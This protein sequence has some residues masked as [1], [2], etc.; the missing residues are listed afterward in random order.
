MRN[1][2]KRTLSLVLAV[3]MLASVAATSI[4]VSANDGA[5]YMHTL[6]DAMAYWESDQEGCYGEAIP[7]TQVYF[8]MPEEWKNE[9]NDYYDGVSLDSCAAGVYWWSGSALPAD[10]LP[11][12]STNAWP[13]Y[14]LTTQEAPGVFSAAVPFDATEIIFNNTIDGGMDSTLDIYTLAVQTSNI[15]MAYDGADP[16]G[17]YP[18]G[19][20][21]VEGMIFVSDPEGKEVNPFNQKV[22]YAGAWFYYYGNGEYGTAPTKAEAGEFVYK[23]GEF[24]SSNLV[25]K[26]ETIN[27]GVGGT[28]SITAN[29]N[30]LTVTFSNEGIATVVANE[31]G[32]YTLQGVAAGTTT[33]TFTYTDEETQE[34]EE[35]TIEVT[36]VEPSFMP[37]SLTMNIGDLEFVIGLGLGENAV[38]SSSNN[39]VITVDSTGT[40]TAVGAGKADI[41]V[42]QGDKVVKCPVTVKAPVQPSLNKKTA[43]LAAGATTTITVKNG[44]ATSWKSSN[45]KVATVKNGKVT[46]LKKGTATITAK[47]NGKSLTC[48][49]TV[50]TNPKL[51]KSTITVKKNKSTTVNIIGAA[52]KPTVSKCQIAKITPSVKKLTI[53]AGKKAGSQKVT[54]T[55][56]GVKLKLTVKVK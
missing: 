4:S 26:P 35:D 3:L 21:S 50:S 37:D 23:N 11:W 20:T 55:V 53:K 17:F 29:K 30:P 52:S 19:L 32:T 56:N 9:H 34:T 36:I 49:V 16:Y 45:A 7:R 14:A 15:P 31:D 22:T 10:Y 24:P 46:A 33:A 40:V 51:A 8:Y 28:K 47:V 18:N 38:W 12:Y 39:K 5:K 54:V 42:T 1:T 41:V 27:V 48:K 6:E 25:V 44:K 2:L 43:K 13:G